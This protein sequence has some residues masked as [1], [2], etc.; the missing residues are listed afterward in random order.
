MRVSREL[1]FPE[2]PPDEMS[3]LIKRHYEAVGIGMFETC[4]AWWAP[5]EKLPPFEI[6]GTEHLEEP[7]KA[8]AE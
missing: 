3:R 2:L 6:R 4:M 5:K 1:C 7:A 8:A